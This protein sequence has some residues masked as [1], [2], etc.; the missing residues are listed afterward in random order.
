MSDYYANTYIKTNDGKLIELLLKS[1]FFQKDREDEYI[2]L[3]G[4]FDLD[5]EDCNVIDLAVLFGI[6]ET[7][8]GEE[9]DV[10]LS[11]IE[12]IRLRELTGIVMG[13]QNRTRK[14]NLSFDEEGY[15]ILDSSSFEL[16]GRFC[17]ALTRY[18]PGTQMICEEYLDYDSCDE[19]YAVA[20]TKYLVK[21]GEMFEIE[22]WQ[23]ER[24]ELDDE[25]E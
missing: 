25:G 16:D 9:G 15:L 21:D 22:S 17:V 13:I 18:Y 23:N 19:F 6:R 4:G 14:V 20:Y 7:H 12:E 8:F 5:K 11:N 10:P 2:L 24:D 1:Y 3:R